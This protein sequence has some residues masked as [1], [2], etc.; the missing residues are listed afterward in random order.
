MTVQGN[1]QVPSLMLPAPA[2]VNLFLHVTGRRADGYHLLESVFVPVSLTDTVRLTCRADGQVRLVNAPPDLSETTEL[3]C[4]AARALQSVSQCTF[5]VDIEL[6]KRIPQGA[7][8]GGGSS[9]AATTLLGLN[10]LWRLGKCRDELQALAA[11]LGAD[12]PFFVFGQAALARGTGDELQAVTLPALHLVVASPGVGVAT[13]S[14][15]T[16]P[17]LERS[18]SALQRPVFTPRF[19]RNDLQAVASRLAPEIGQLDHAMKALGLAPRMT[20][21][22]SCM[23]ALGHNAS[24]ADRMRARL[25]DQKWRAWT[26]FTLRRHPIYGFANSARI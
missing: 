14:V 2:K 26:V 13:Q 16:H 7:G 1:E 12:V 6:V 20:G 25:I 10:R 3:A 8:L 21:S 4:R 17:D 5:G 24:H 11:T 23:F 9:D 15:F 19:G 22:G 18:T